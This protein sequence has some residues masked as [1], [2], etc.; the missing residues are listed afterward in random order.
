MSSATFILAAAAVI[1]LCAAA[2]GYTY[3]KKGRERHSGSGAAPLAGHWTPPGN[4]PVSDS[5]AKSGTPPVPAARGDKVRGDPDGKVVWGLYARVGMRQ[6]MAGVG[7]IA[8]S[9]VFLVL[10]VEFGSP[11]LEVDSV[12]AFVVA[13]ILLLKESRSRVQSRVLSAVVGSLGATIAQLSSKVGSSFTY[14]PRGKGVSDVAILRSDSG[15]GEAPGSGFSVTPPGMGL[16]VLFARE[17][18]GS[19]MSVDSL[20][21]LLPSIITENFGLAEAVDVSSDGNLVEV[22]LK[23]PAVFCS[24][25]EDESRGTGVVGC[26]ISSFLA[27]LYSYASRKSVSLNRCQVDKDSDRWKVSMFLLERSE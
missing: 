20:A 22:T 26:T 12:V 27:V 6:T 11:V 23:K 4:R 24:C 10:S 17:A 9:I 16:G 25:P 14:V 2:F 1:A 18:E 8:A 3:S 13:A 15:P 5:P 19:P 7:F 21:H